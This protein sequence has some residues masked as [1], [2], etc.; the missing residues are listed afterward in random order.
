MTNEATQLIQR[1][2][3]FAQID[4][5]TD[6]ANPDSLIG[7]FQLFRPAGQR[8]RGLFDDL[9]CG[10]KLHARLEELFQVAGEDRRREGGRDAYFIVRNFQPI[11][12]QQVTTLAGEWLGNLAS[13]A[14]EVGDENA[15]GLFQPTP[16]IR[17]LEGHAP[18]HP[19]A[20]EEKCSLLTA[21]QASVPTW[22]Q[23]MERS[24]AAGDNSVSDVLRQAYYYICCD[25]MLR[26]YLM[27]PLYA[28]AWQTRDPF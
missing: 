26:D 14:I 27:W 19:K 24:V 4:S 7:F 25:P 9:D 22:C 23:Q 28:H 21:M 11:D 13:L 5:E 8:L 3:E 17:V 1:C 18:K 6:V 20:A 2:H 15:V 10:T 16:T 12:A